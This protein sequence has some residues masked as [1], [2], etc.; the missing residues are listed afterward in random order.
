MQSVS[1]SIKT[2][3][4]IISCRNPERESRML[5]VSF[6]RS[7]AGKISTSLSRSFGGWSQ[8]EVMEY[9]DDLLYDM[10]HMG[11]IMK[12]VLIPDSS[13]KISKC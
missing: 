1:F 13:Q 6:K 3:E 10:A 2:A 7:S 5:S 8:I 12:L 4:S 11:T 9:D